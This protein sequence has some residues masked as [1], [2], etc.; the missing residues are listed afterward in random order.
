MGTGEA[1]RLIRAGSRKTAIKGTHESEMFRA[2]RLCGIVSTP[3][4]VLRT[5]QGK[6]PT[7]A[8][9]LRQTHGRRG[10]KVFLISAGHHWQLVSGNRFVCGQTGDVVALDHPKVHRRS[11]VRAVWL[12]EAPTGVSIPPLARKPKARPPTAYAQA[13]RLAKR[14]HLRIERDGRDYWVFGP[15]GL[16]EDEHGDPKDDPCE[17]CHF[18][19]GWI[20][21]LEKVQAYVEDLQAREMKAAA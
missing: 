14:W 21:V 13:V 5:P 6:Q 11:R 16:Y 1:A 3:H 7:L 2:L 9:W 12:L 10:G 4:R 20:E 17:G 15:E 18:S 19:V 8:E